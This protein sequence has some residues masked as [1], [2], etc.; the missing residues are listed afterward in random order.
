MSSNRNPDTSENKHG[1][2]SGQSIPPYEKLLKAIK[3]GK[4][5]KSV[6]K[7][8]TENPWQNDDRHEYELKAFK[9]YFDSGHLKE[10]EVLKLLLEHSRLMDP[11]RNI[12]SSFS[13][14]TIIGDY[15]DDYYRIH[16]DLPVSIKH[17]FFEAM[18]RCNEMFMANILDRFHRY[19]FKFNIDDFKIYLGSHS[20]CMADVYCY[21]F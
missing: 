7:I 1:L 3:N 8:F 17:C 10:I 20:V 11:Q 12:T 13:L 5:E 4:S 9:L 6:K 19:K 15:F 18:L 21:L 14:L 16:M 2:F